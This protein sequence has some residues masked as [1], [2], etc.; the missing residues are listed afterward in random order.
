MDKKIVRFTKREVRWDLYPMF[1]NLMK[2]GFR[3]EAYLLMLSTWNFA[4]FRYAWHGFNLGSF[5]KK[6]V[7]LKK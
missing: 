2:A 3:T 4:N 1:L 6:L 7:E 5:E